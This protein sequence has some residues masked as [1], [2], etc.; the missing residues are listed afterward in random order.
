[1]SVW[2]WC[3]QQI[4]KARKKLECDSRAATQNQGH[5]ERLSN[6]RAQMF[7]N[8][9][10][11]RLGAVSCTCCIYMALLVF[12]AG[13]MHSVKKC[14]GVVCLS[15]SNISISGGREIQISVV[16]IILVLLRVN[17][18]DYNILKRAVGGAKEFTSISIHHRDN[19]HA[20]CL[21]N[22]F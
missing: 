16:R 15:K 12:N 1:M 11:L 18:L 6:S 4:L 5:F 20:C 10:T 19:K 9:L 8:V 22:A 7:G 2:K 14:N 3:K 13:K 21:P 17:S